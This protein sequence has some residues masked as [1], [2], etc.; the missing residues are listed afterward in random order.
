M[1]VA[2]YWATA[3][4]LRTSLFLSSSVAP[5]AGMITMSS[6]VR[7]SHKSASVAPASASRPLTV[8]GR[9]LS[10]CRNRRPR[11]RRS[12]FTKGLWISSL[13]MK[14]RRPGFSASVS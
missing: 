11:R 10:V 9:P 1:Q 3:M 4:P 8:K 12:S 7:V 6:L 14:T 13:S 5:K 2:S